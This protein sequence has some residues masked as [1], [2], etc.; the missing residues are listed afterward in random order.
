MTQSNPNS[1]SA[2]ERI[3]INLQVHIGAGEGVPFIQKK[4]VFPAGTV[5]FQDPLKPDPHLGPAAPVA[6]GIKV[7]IIAGVG[8]RSKEQHFIE[9][10]QALCWALRFSHFPI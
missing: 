3:K 5:P 10:C 6:R 4:L 7:T 1:V 2:V 9:C 8:G